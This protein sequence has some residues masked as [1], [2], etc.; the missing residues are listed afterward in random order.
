MDINENKENDFL[1]ILSLAAREPRGRN[2]LCS[3]PITG[4]LTLSPV[5]MAMNHTTI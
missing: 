4:V 3:I 2:A 5:R 1:C